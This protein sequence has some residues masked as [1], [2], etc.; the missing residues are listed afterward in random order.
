MSTR[1]RS[2]FGS[3]K[4]LPDE[5]PGVSPDDASSADG[6]DVHPERGWVT[7]PDVAGAEATGQPTAVQHG[8]HLRAD[9]PGATPQEPLDPPHPPKHARSADSAEPS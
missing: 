2:D 6:T 8:A 9:E 4:I 1:D 5:L 7:G 3:G